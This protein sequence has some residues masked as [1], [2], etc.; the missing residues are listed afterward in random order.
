MFSLGYASHA[1]LPQF[2]YECENRTRVITIKNKGNDNTD[3][4]LNR[5]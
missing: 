1:I 5:D 2:A 3:R 4:M